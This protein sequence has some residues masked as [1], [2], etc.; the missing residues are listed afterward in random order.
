MFCASARAEVPAAMPGGVYVLDNRHTS[1]TFK[2]SHLGFS[3]FTGRFDKVEGSFDFNPQ[4]PLESLVDVTIYP[5][6]IDTN[7]AELDEDLRGEN[8]FDT[9]KFPR[10][11]FHATQIDVTGENRARITG[12]FSMHNITHRLVLDAVV[13]GAG[14]VPFSNAH[15]IGFS[16]SGEFDRSDYG[17]S[18]LEPMVGDEVTLQIETEFDKE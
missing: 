17:I 4:S 11:A 18:N 8:W 1:I 9:L 7:D 10:A 3:H 14:D 13:V 15:V 6:S 16:A 12:D 2:I 5:G